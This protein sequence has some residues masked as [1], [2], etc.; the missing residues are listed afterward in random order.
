MAQ[1]IQSTK[2][3]KKIWYQIQSTK[4]LNNVLLGE[5]YVYNKDQIKGKSLKLNLSTVSNDMRK[6]NMDVSFEVISFVDN[7]AIASVTGV[8]L[9]QSFLK[10]LV[11]RGRDKIED[12]FLAKTKDKKTIR[13]KPVI[14]TM[15]RSAMTIKSKIRLQARELIRNLIKTKQHEE[16][17]GNVIH[18]KIQ[19][20]LKETLSKIYPVKQL[21]LRQILIV[22]D[23]GKSKGSETT[24]DNETDESQSADEVV[25]LEDKEVDLEQ[26]KII[27]KPKAEK[28]PAKTASNAQPIGELKKAKK[29]PEGKVVDKP[30]SEQKED[31]QVNEN[32]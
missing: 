12:S 28:K 19:K 27:E 22:T 21:E 24:V 4:T 13:V 11:R 18:Q 6:Q 3:R 30:N 32:D 23:K 15:N 25:Q 2:K 20:E 8:S 14:I 29:K 7:K 26:E 1:L 9:T 17:F 10:R 31:S 16:F 5:T